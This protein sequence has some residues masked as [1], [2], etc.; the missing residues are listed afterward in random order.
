[1]LAGSGSGGAAWEVP[2]I[3]LRQEFDEL[4]GLDCHPFA[5]C[6]DNVTPSRS[7]RF[8]YGVDVAPMSYQRHERGIQAV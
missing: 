7:A 3:A 6:R 1:M 2:G 5:S 8:S 4:A